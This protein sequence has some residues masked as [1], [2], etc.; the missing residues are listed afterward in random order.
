MGLALL[1][2][3]LGVWWGLSGPAGR[4]PTYEEPLPPGPPA[5]T[6]PEMDQVLFTALEK[7]GIEPESL[8]VS[9]RNG[10]HGELT[11]VRAHLGPRRGLEA[12]AQSISRR[13]RAY[14]AQVK[15]LPARNGLILEASLGGRL[16]HR[17]RLLPPLPRPTPPP[18]ARRPR[19][20]L[21]VDDLGYDLQ[22]ARD[23]AALGIPLTVSVLPFSPHA[24]EIARLAHARGLQVML[25]LPMEPQGYPQVDPGPGALLTSMSAQELADKTLRALNSVPY[26]AGANNH[27]G[28][29][30]TRQALRLVPVLSVL[31]RRGLFFVD[32]H[33][34]AGSQGLYTARRLGLPSARRG[35]FLDNQASEQAVGRQIQRM[36]KLARQRGAVI[37]I[38]HPHPATLQALRKWAPVLRKNCELVLVSALV[39]APLAGQERAR[40]SE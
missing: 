21:L 32:S 25:H 31:K 29:A 39:R 23:L 34:A 22:P 37:A 24:G 1:L 2:L 17:L 27:M 14:G 4:P 10:A 36:L 11:M 6:L 20:A 18:R 33:T 7:A 3:G 19:V 30:F 5:H 13:L 9:Y 38:A 35:I 15:T 40:A 8:L 28:S 12:A 26:A 16:T